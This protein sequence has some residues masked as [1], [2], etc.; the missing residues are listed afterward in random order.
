MDTEKQNYISEDKLERRNVYGY[1][2]YPYE[3]DKLNPVSI[4]QLASSIA[5]FGHNIKPLYIEL[6]RQEGKTTEFKF[7]A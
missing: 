2:R 1:E 5:Q 6:M 4:L 7:E 3:L